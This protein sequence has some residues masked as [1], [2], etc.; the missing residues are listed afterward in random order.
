MNTHLS[1]IIITYNAA[2][3]LVDCLNS[4][5]FVSEILILDSGS[6]DETRNIAQQ[7]NARF[8]HQD[9]L[10]YGPQKQKAVELAEHDW[11]LCL[12]ADECI[13]EELAVSIQSVMESPQY[14]AYQFPRCNRF[15]GRW[16]RHGEGYPDI[17]LRLFNRQHALWSNDAV[18]EF[19]QTDVSTGTLKGD[20]LHDSA[21][22][23]ASY[24]E[25]QNQYTSLQAE[26]MY[27]AGKTAGVGKILL[28][29]LFRF[30]KFYLFRLGFLDGVPGLVH[31]CIGCQN[32]FI[33]YAKLITLQRTQ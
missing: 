17:S 24:L 5:S 1:A 16:L 28:N 29:P 30:F 9:W 27:Q 3:Q 4:L 6:D 7:Y 31:I 15:M 25:K 14:Q 21:A 13:S 19:V 2:R 32:T 11:V 12:D 8:I 33:K 22:S 26:K 23:L 20:L 10:G 18:H